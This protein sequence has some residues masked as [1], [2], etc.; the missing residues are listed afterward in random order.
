MSSLQEIKERADKVL[1]KAYSRYPV[2]VK[3][4]RGSRIWDFD[5][6][7]YIDLLAGIAVTSVGHCHP[8]VTKA[9]CEQMSKLVHASNLFYQE[10]Q[11]LLAEKLVQTS[12]CKKAS[13]SA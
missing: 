5:G 11:V 4:A 7:E 13:N 9:I 12:H 1:C 8:E 3:E 6:R 10:E 2:G